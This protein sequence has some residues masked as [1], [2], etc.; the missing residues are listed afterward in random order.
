MSPSYMS[1]KEIKE[2]SLMLPPAPVVDWT[3][4]NMPGVVSTTMS[5]VSRIGV[6][7]EFTPAN[8]LSSCHGIALEPHIP[9]IVIA[10]HASS[11]ALIGL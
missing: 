8:K 6:I 4:A 3:W 1:P 9:S 11:T 5:S 2:P 10:Y 7:I